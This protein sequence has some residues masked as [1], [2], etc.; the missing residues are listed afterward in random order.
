MDATASRVRAAFRGCPVIVARRASPA[1]GCRGRLGLKG[2]RVNEGQTVR[3]VSVGLLANKGRADP[4]GRRG[5]VVS[6][7]R[8]ASADRKG[9]LLV[10]RCGDLSSS[11]TRTDS[12]KK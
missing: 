10:L 2:R 1:L 7:V 11:A 8:T 6:V 9:R 5:L 3:A 4:K 12:Q